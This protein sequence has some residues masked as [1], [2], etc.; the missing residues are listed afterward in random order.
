M[1]TKNMLI[2]GMSLALVACISVG[3][4]LAYLSDTTGTV[5][6]KFQMVTNGIVLNLQE[7]AKDGAGYDVYTAKLEDS[8]LKKDQ[9][10]TDTTTGET[11]NANNAG[12]IVGFIYENIQP[13]AILQKDVKLSIGQQGTTTVSSWVFACIENS[14]GANM[15][16]T[17]NSQNWKVVANDSEKHK[18]LYL[19]QGT[20]AS[21]G[22]NNQKYIPEFENVKELP[23]L[24]TTV[25]VPAATQPNA[26]FN[27]IIVSG[28]AEQAEA[29]T[30]AAAYANALNHF[31][32]TADEQ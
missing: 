7:T 5:Q 13:G 23:S 17:V 2:G 20:L 27:D 11:L 26:S 3:A 4:T 8:Q 19:Y 29:N 15:T 14:N 16:V 22:D 21:A 31:G 30:Y 25:E 18:T 10:V 32:M 24:F 6:N 9:K 12:E 1:K 28:Y